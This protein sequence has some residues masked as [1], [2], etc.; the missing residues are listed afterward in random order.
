MTITQ[1][2]I[3]NI[4]VKNGEIKPTQQIS[5]HEAINRYFIVNKVYAESFNLY[6]GIAYKYNKDMDIESQAKRING[7]IYSLIEKALIDADLIVLSKGLIRQAGFYT[8]EESMKA[9]W[10]MHTTQVINDKS[11]EEIND[12][13]NKALIKNADHFQIGVTTEDNDYLPVSNKAMELFTKDL[14]TGY[15]RSVNEW[16]MEA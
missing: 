7:T 1:K 2:Q 10:L 8:N 13:V 16:R 6:D 3:Y 14:Q 12:I 5:A 4:L 15:V 9:T 11:I